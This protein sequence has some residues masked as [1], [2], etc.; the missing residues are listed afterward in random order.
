MPFGS[1]FVATIFEC[2]LSSTED[3]TVFKEWA[4]TSIIV[5]LSVGHCRWSLMR[6]VDA[7]SPKK[8]T[9]IM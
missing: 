3:A 5:D 4:V 1:D 8:N 7:M 6:D 9:M 2:L